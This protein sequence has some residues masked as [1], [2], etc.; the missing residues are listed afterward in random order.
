MQYLADLL[1]LAVD[2]KLIN[3]DDLYTVEDKIIEKLQEDEEL[4]SKWN[5]FRN[6]SQ[7]FTS[8]EKPNN[9]YWVNIPAKRR[10][11][12]PQVVSKG[13][14]SDLSE[15]VSKDIDDFL[16]VDFNIWLSGK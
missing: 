2:K 1:K 10:Y 9:G 14:V 13:R 16:N 6:L 7:I 5:D 8:K 3:M 4:K 11:I 15:E 12:N